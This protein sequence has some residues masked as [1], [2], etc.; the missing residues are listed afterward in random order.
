MEGVGYEQR[1][2]VP[3]KRADL[4]A[5]AHSILHGGLTDG[6]TIQIHLI[7]LCVKLQC[8]QV[9]TLD[10]AVVADRSLRRTVFGGPLASGRIEFVT[11]FLSGKLALVVGLVKSNLQIHG[12]PGADGGLSPSDG[13]QCTRGCWLWNGGRDALDS[14]LDRVSAVLLFLS[15]FLLFGFDTCSLTCFV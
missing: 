15:G 13:V 7:S 3:F 4:M 9:R 1:T 6:I 11:H 8:A 5:E 12:I 14:L 2:D 10:G